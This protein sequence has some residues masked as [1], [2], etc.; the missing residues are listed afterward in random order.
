MDRDPILDDLP[1]SHLNRNIANNAN[2]RADYETD[3]AHLNRVMSKL[4]NL[5]VS[6]ERDT[7]L[8]VTSLELAKTSFVVGKGFDRLIQWLKDALKAADRLGDRRSTAMLNLHLGRLYYFGEQR[9]LAMDVFA[10]G[11]AEVETLGD[12]D[13]VANAAELIGL[14]FFIQGLYPKAM[15]YFEQAAKRF[16]FG[17]Q[18]HSGPMWLS[19]CAAFLGQYHQ[20]IGTLDFYRRLAIERGDHTLATTLRSVLGI[21]LV[22]IK[23]TKEAAYHLSGALQEGK[24]TQNTLA[25]YFAMGGLAFHHMMEDRL[26]E[27]RQWMVRTMTEGAKAGLIHQYASPFVLEVLFEF[28]RNGLAPIRDFT[29]IEECRRLMTEPNIHLQGVALRLMALDTMMA[30]GEV[31][32]RDVETELK[33]SERLLLQSGDP[34]QLGKTRIAMTRLKLGQGDPVAA[35]HLAQNAWKNFSGYSDVFY[36]DDLRRLLTDTIKNAPGYAGREELMDMFSAMIQDLIPSDDPDELLQRMVRATNRFF[37][38]ERGG[39]FWFRRSQ[40]RK[41]P[42]LRATCNL[43]QSDIDAESFRTNLT[44]V[45][46]SYRENRPQVVRHPGGSSLPSQIQA[47]MA[48][49]FQ[50][51][52]QVRGVL[53]HDNAYVN[54]CFDQFKGD[55][56]THMAQSLSQ[57]V[58]HM[59][60]FTRRLKQQTTGQLSRI[61]QLDQREIIGQSPAL[62]EV[63]DQADRIAGTDST[64]LILG[65]TG[66]GKE[67]LAKRIHNRSPRRDNPL[68][69]MDPT[70]IPE[71][72]VESELFGHEKGA[73]TGAD[74]QRAG[75]IELANN[76]TLFIDEVGEIPMG[77][78]V[79]LLRTIQEK[80]M[81]RVGGTQTLSINF[82][83]I[84]A[85]N[86][87]LAE[88]VKKGR[89]REDFYYRL[90]VIP[91]VL[92][93][94]RDRGDDILLLA[95]QFIERFSG[96]HNRPVLQLTPDAEAALK[97]Y[98]WPGNIRE[99]ENTLERSVLLSPNDNLELS[100]PSSRKR[101][102]SEHPFEDSPSLE[103]VQRRYISFVLKKTNGKI[104]GEDGAAVLLGMKRTSLY[105]RMKKL[106]LR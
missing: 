81:V 58:G 80:T 21:F 99:L 26:E 36:P 97:N 8:V 30:E 16:E 51:E 14:Y 79:K 84:A 90:N 106:G 40:T 88:E 20:A 7:L 73:F 45:F 53:Y 105:K 6:T 54:D 1:T 74:R 52:D 60:R 2:N 38:A 89:F 43:S 83:L 17:E 69:V 46:N 87:N 37:G 18:G 28:H 68:V 29:F 47:M 78:Q 15:P 48:V 103:E 32:Y 42:I 104:A 94:L 35:R 91:V 61:G 24:Q 86:R 57:Y 76:G 62:K 59:L 55:Q 4:D 96:K 95:H 82:R 22:R 50:I 27:S 71:S 66:V 11:K 75:R 49:P 33:Q 44:V 64:V 72:L 93:P 65:E 100:M 13:I 5:P 3:W 101:F 34:V 63:L 70:A 12:E 19:Y 10:C 77:I 25:C 98:D 41:A 56:L 85:T 102:P 9:H 31:P 92:P 23:K 39:I 67:L